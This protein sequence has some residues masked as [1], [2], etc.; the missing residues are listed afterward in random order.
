MRSYDRARALRLLEAIEHLWRETTEADS[1]P[2]LAYLAHRLA[3]E[4]TAIAHR[5][6][7]RSAGAVRRMSRVFS[8]TGFTFGAS[9][10][11]RLPPHAIYLNVGQLGWAAPTTAH[12]LRGRPDI[13]SVF[14]LHDVI[15]LQHPDLVSRGGLLS[16]RWMLSTVARHAD[17]LITTTEAASDTVLETLRRRGHA[18]VAALS[19][20]LPV[21]PVFL[22]PDRACQEISR[23]NYFVICGAV[24]P[25]KNHL[26][27]LRIWQ[28]LV[29]TRGAMAPY[30]IIL[31][32]PAHEGRHIL[33]Q[34]T[35]DATLRRHVITLSGLP[36]P[37]LRRV[38]ANAQ[39]VLMPSLAEGFGLP[40]VE[41]LTVGTPV[42]ASD[43]PAHR[44][45]G[46]DLACYL[47]PHEPADWVAAI[48]RLI[49]APEFAAT[50]RRRIAAYRPM[51]AEDY[52][53][54]V[55]PFLANLP[56]RRAATGG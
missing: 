54:R 55:V 47:S 30:L 34:F 5:A 53:A 42:L 28:N 35:A 37:A 33:Q 20:H 50:L 13:T 31:G 6:R 38:M 8:T 26:L 39:A 48:L 22:Q 1:D 23:Y 46:G 2:L 7:V 19:L 18:E 56:E 27:L 4:D 45:V 40:V 12:W 3:G 44:E 17:A 52:F 32:S 24:E 51:L 41:A 16:L 9:A 21:A 49:D 14:M 11:R 15:P 29:R 25:R 10:P 36:S 43:L